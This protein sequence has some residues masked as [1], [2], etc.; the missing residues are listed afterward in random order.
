MIFDLPSCSS[1]FD[2]ASFSFKIAK[3]LPLS[4]GYTLMLSF[5]QRLDSANLSDLDRLSFNF[6]P[7]DLDK[8]LLTFCRSDSVEVLQLSFSKPN[9]HLSV[10]ETMS[11]YG[12][13]FGVGTK[14]DTRFN[15]S[16][17]TSSS[18]LLVRFNT[19]DFTM[20]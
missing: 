7:I 11:K 20:L 9:A 1:N 3:P 18:S 15:N 6:L 4:K 19:P 12:I 8:I 10:D 14:F 17:V 2:K 13:V 5:F 16:N